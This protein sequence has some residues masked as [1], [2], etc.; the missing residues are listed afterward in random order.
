MCVVDSSLNVK[1]GDFGLTVGTDEN[2]IYR[3]EN[4]ALLPIKWTSPESVI[5]GIFSTASDIW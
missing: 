1:L 5:H 3:S 4:N 2:G